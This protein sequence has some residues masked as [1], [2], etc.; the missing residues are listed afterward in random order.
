MRSKTFFNGRMYIMRV[1]NYHKHDNTS[2]LELETPLQI[3]K[4][5]YGKEAYEQAKQFYH[6]EECER[7]EK[8]QLN[9]DRRNYN[10]KANLSLEEYDE[11]ESSEKRKRRLNDP[12]SFVFRA[13]TKLTNGFDELF[14]D[15]ILQESTQL[16]TKKQYSALYCT[17]KSELNTSEIAE[18]MSTT[19]RAV[20]KLLQRALKK[21]REEYVSLFGEAKAYGY[22]KCI[23]HNYKRILRFFEQ[24]EIILTKNDPAA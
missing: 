4:E 10:H 7:F 1:K 6:S 8:E 16:L 17:F 5:I 20:Q 3:Y 19:V 22:P 14:E 15:P 23:E 9:S 2:V 13:E 21:L 18:L 24:Y 11:W 12:P